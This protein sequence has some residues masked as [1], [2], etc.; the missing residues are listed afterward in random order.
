MMRKMKIGRDK[1]VLATWFHVLAY[2]ILIFSLFA[3]NAVALVILIPSALACLVLGVALWL[4]SVWRE[5]RE[6]GVL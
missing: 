4:L 3:K 6:K 2:V 1:I 5:A